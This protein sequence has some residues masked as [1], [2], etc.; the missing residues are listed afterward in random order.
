MTDGLAYNPAFWSY[1]L[2]AI[3]FTAFAV[4][5]GIAWRGGLRASILLGAI[6]A[7]ALWACAVALA[8]AFPQSREGWIAAGVLDV[9]RIGAWLAF[10]ALLLDGWHPGRAGR[11]WST[12]PRP[13]I[14][15]AAVLLVGGRPRPRLR[16]PARSR[17]GPAATGGFLALLGLAILGLVLV[18]QLWRRTPEHARWGIKPLVIGLAGRAGRSTSSSTPT[19]CSSGTSTRRSGRRAA[20]CTRS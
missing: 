15:I 5:L 4:R 19:R 16:V 7:S 10:L 17:A 12:T 6:V 13:L 1:G 9:A 20:S 3:L 8:L 18:E 11:P 2:A 14:A